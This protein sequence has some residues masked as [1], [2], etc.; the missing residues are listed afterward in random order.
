M[1][2]PPPMMIASTV[3]TSASRPSTQRT[4]RPPAIQ[5]LKAISGKMRQP[6]RRDVVTPISGLVISCPGLAQPSLIKDL[7][8]APRP[9]LSR[10]GDHPVIV[11]PRLAQTGQDLGILRHPLHN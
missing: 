7:T 8:T 10:Y 6:E 4:A 9:A 2:S 1:S 5:T 3:S 11:F